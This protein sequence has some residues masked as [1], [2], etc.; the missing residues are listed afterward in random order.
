MTKLMMS[1]AALASLAIAVPGV[2]NAEPVRV[3][4]QVADLDLSSAEGRATAE[5][6]A[7]HAAADACGDRSSADRMSGPAIK[8][9]RADVV[10]DVLAKARPVQLAKR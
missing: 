10:A 8:Q 1:M 2:A 6:R 5:Q 4:V 3:S 7:Q 9:C